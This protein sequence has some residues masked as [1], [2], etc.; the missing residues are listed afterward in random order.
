M[1]TLKKVSAV[2]LSSV[3][4]ATSLAGCGYL[5]DTPFSE[6][7]SWSY[8][9]DNSTLSIGTYIFE[10]FMA[11]QN[12]A[13]Q[14][15]DSS[16]DVLTEKVKNDDEKEVT[17]KDFVLSKAELECKKILNVNKT[18]EDMKLSLTDTEKAAAVNNSTSAWQ[19]YGNNLKKYGISKESF[20]EAYGMYDQKYT[21]I[22]KT[23]YGEG[24]EKEVSKS[25]IEKYFKENF[26]DYSFFSVPLYDSNTS[27]D[28]SAASSTTAKSEA[29]IKKIKESLDGYAKS[30][31]EDGKSFKDA[32]EA[33]MK[34]YN[35]TDD[36][37]TTNV[38][39]LDDSG[40][41]DEIKKAIKDLKENKAAVIKVGEDNNNA[42]YY[43]VYK[44]AIAD[45]VKTLSDEKSNMSFQVIKKLK[46][47]EYEKDMTEAAKKIKCETNESAIS[48]YEPSMFIEQTAATN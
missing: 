17:G 7:I 27:D 24:G 45:Q 33:Y 48:K 34:D 9:D 36:P 3:V 12:A 26:T 21:K 19:Y 46:S 14:I 15:N 30:I 39:V 31:N 35:I 13:Q 20:I 32:T 6:D 25:D 29:E 41:G 43:L 8:K 47:D 28:A 40:L 42:L 5:V 37:T 10:E 11:Y 23:L 22:F 38:A 2:L 18:F 44:G 4:A 1:K 16:K